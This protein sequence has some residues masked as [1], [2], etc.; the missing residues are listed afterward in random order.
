MKEISQNSDRY[1]KQGGD[2]VISASP[3]IKPLTLPIGIPLQGLK[4]VITADGIIVKVGDA[5]LCSLKTLNEIRESQNPH[6]DIVEN[7]KLDVKGK[8][9]SIGK[10]VKIIELD[11]AKL[12]GLIESRK[13]Q[14][15]QAGVKSVKYINDRE[16]LVDGIPVGLIKQIDYTLTQEGER[17]SDEYSVV[18][19]FTMTNPAI[20]PSAAHYTIKPIRTITDQQETIFD[21]LKLQTFIIELDNQLRLLRRDFNSIKETFFNGILPTGSVSGV[22]VENKVAR[23]DIDDVETDHSFK[24]TESNLISLETPPIKQVQDDLDSTATQIQNELQRTAQTLQQRSISLEE[25][26]RRAQAGDT[27]TQSYI[28][29]Q[30]NA[31]KAELAAIKQKLAK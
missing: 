16:T 30:L 12:D 14:N 19:Y 5:H 2:W 7:G 8:G 25:A 28:Q 23:T 1:S 3:D 10:T 6:Y 29:G 31:A 4:P 13:L 24:L 27:A 20:N 18:D 11:I 21:P 26:L 22:I 9:V 15:K 17:P